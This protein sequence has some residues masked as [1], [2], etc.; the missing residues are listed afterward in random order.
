MSACCIYTPLP[1]CLKSECLL[2]IYSSAPLSD[3]GT[4]AAAAANEALN[5]PNHMLVS[6]EAEC[7]ICMDVMD[8]PVSDDSRLVEENR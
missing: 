7:S 2:H 1:L 3:T 4:T 6:S 8:M 5:V